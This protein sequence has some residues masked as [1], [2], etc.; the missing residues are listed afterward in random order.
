MV[1]TTHSLRVLSWTGE[2]Q[3]PDLGERS[4]SKFDMAVGDLDLLRVSRL[5]A[6]YLNLCRAYCDAVFL[7]KS[8]KCVH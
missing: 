3:N 7:L 6:V 8:Q 5:S 2:G 1:T 4:S